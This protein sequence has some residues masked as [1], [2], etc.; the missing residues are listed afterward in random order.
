MSLESPLFQS[1]FE[2]FSHSIE[3]FN[4]KEELDRKLVILHLSNAVEL[5]LKDI[6]LDNGLSIYK[7]PKETITIQKSLEMIKNEINITLKHLNK[8]ELLIDER[9]GLQHRY[10]SPSEITTIFYMEVTHSFFEDILI[11][12]YDEDFLELL[13]QYLSEASMTSYMLRQPESISE[14]DKVKA[15][16]SI[17]PTGALLS[18]MNYYELL[19]KDFLE[20]NG[21][22]EERR[23]YPGSYSHRMIT[24]LGVEMDSDFEEELHELRYLRNRV[25]HGKGE[26]TKPIVEAAINTISRFESFLELIDVEK[27]KSIQAEDSSESA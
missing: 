10:G 26:A 24:R 14:L 2:L 25:S 1:A 6:I 19:I 15:I 7:N 20:S 9:N 5:I 16:A 21:F 11:E 27:L 8:I 23:I 13:K 22:I 3:H 12:H 4:S 18:A 17:H